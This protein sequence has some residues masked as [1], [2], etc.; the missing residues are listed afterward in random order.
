MRSGVVKF[1]ITSNESQNIY[2]NTGRDA[3]RDAHIETHIQRLADAYA[4][5]QGRRKAEEPYYRNADAVMQWRR[6]LD[7]ATETQVQIYK[8]A[9]DA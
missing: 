9:K 6:Q 5:Q 4:E 3:G 7:A 8:H 1:Y 2:F